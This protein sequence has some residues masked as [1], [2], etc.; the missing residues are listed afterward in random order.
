MRCGSFRRRF[1]KRPGRGCELRTVIDIDSPG[2]VPFVVEL[3]VFVYQAV[4]KVDCG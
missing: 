4:A 1:Q 2:I 3:R